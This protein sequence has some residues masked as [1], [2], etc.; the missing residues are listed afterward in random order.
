MRK[1]LVSIYNPGAESPAGRVGFAPLRHRLRRPAPAGPR[2]PARTLLAPLLALLLVGTGCEQR[3]P[4]ANPGRPTGNA[5][6]AVPPVT[7]G[8]ARP[9][10]PDSATLAR[11]DSLATASWGR[12]ADSLSGVAGAAHRFAPAPPR[13]VGLRD[14]VG[15]GRAARLIGGPFNPATL[16][17]QR[18]PAVPLMLKLARR[19]TLM[20][21]V[22]SSES[23]LYHLFADAQVPARVVA[24]PLAL[25]RLAF[26]PGQ[27]RLNAE[28]A[29]Q[30]GSLAALLHTFP[31]VKLQLSGH[32]APT[33]PQAAALSAARAQASRAE[34][35]KL[36]VAPARLVVVALPARPND[37]HPQ[38]LSVRVVA[39]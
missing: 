5:P 21:G 4:A 37:P 8:P 11:A 38:G 17:Y 7:V 32:A 20:V 26:A 23:R 15:N 2:W 31:K 18:E 10:P 24:N 35:L 12:A 33:E 13:F 22:N 3:P 14:T 30:L 39:R 6:A 19:T 29:Q 25:D 28:G 34:L 1:L 27:A 36:G 9:A 16:R